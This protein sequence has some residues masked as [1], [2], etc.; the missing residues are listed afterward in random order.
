[1]FDRDEFARVAGEDDLVAIRIDPVSGASSGDLTQIHYTSTN[2]RIWRNADKSG[3]PIMSDTPTFNAQTTATIYVEG[4]KLSGAV[5]AEKIDLIYVSANAGAPH[6]PLSTL[7]F[8]IYKVT[9]V[10]DVP[11]F[12]AHVYEATLPGPIGAT[13]GPVGGGTIILPLGNNAP[14][15]GATVNTVAVKWGGGELEG[16]LKV[17]APGGFS[18]T[19]E[20]NVVKVDV[21]LATGDSQFKLARGADYKTSQVALGSKLTVQVGGQF[22]DVGKW[23]AMYASLK[24]TRFAPPMVGTQLRGGKF[25]DLGFIQGVTFSKY[26]ADFANTGKRETSPMEGLTLIDSVYKSGKGGKPWMGNLPTNPQSPPGFRRY[27]S[28]ADEV[29]TD[30]PFDAFDS[31][32]I[33]MMVKPNGAQNLTDMSSVSLTMDFTLDFAVHTKEPDNGANLSYTVRASTGGW[34]WNGSGTVAMSTWT[35]LPAEQALTQGTTVFSPVDTGRIVPVALTQTNT[36]NAWLSGV[37]QQPGNVSN[38]RWKE[39]NL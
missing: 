10:L 35:A 39:T 9:G 4:L 25:I 6:V 23:P 33:Y 26:H 28:P 17:N 15:P 37:A 32:S 18:M 30:R 13:Y 19:R 20:V 34:K 3:W 5:N 14:V 24:V 16:T 12:S 7:S 8:T 2:I 27:Y 36:A 38:L 31:M 22:A 29:L 21:S 1:M 11:G